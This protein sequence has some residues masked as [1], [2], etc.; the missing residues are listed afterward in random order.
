MLAGS[1]TVYIGYAKQPVGYETRLFVQKDIDIPGARNALND[2]PDEIDPL[3]GGKVPTDEPAH[4][5]KI[6]IHVA[7]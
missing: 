3:R 1:L 5:T 7:E 2:L 4:V 6:L